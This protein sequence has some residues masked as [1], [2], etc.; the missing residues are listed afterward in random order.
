M[1]YY[2]QICSDIDGKL[3]F[4][5]NVS[6]SSLFNCFALISRNVGLTRAKFL[7]Y[8]PNE[9]FA[10]GP[11]IINGKRSK[12]RGREHNMHIML[13]HARSCIRSCI[14]NFAQ[15]YRSRKI[16]LCKEKKEERRL[17]GKKDSITSKEQQKKTMFN[18]RR[19]RPQ[20][21][22]TKWTTCSQKSIIG[23]KIFCHLR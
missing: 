4:A 11:G 5:L 17:F 13:L 15:R 16:D 10:P 23:A 20:S 1:P 9:T 8:F 22:C 2:T 19:L 14:C 3:K 21:R 18:S 7:S 6:R 12:K